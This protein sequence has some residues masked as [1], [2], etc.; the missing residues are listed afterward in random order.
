MRAALGTSNHLSV[1]D[2]HTR[3]AVASCRRNRRLSGN[4]EDR[5]ARAR[6]CRQRHEEAWSSS[7]RTGSR[8][9]K[10]TSPTIRSAPP[11]GE[12]WHQSVN[13]GRSVRCIADA[14]SRYRTHR[15]GAVSWYPPK[16]PMLVEVR[17]GALEPQSTPVELT[18]SNWEAVGYMA[19]MLRGRY[20][21]MASR[22]RSGRAGHYNS[23]P[24][25]PFR[26]SSESTPR[27]F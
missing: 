23:R 16:A 10:P 8:P 21:M 1:H 27:R 4:H 18:R 11:T 20:G 15:C 19:I 26:G 12:G 13:R 22:K 17:F 14:L 5:S 7:R 9:P 3:M 25:P 24:W 2:V 6:R